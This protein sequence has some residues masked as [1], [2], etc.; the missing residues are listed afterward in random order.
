MRRT[1]LMFTFGIAL[2]IA[3]PGFLGAGDGAAEVITGTWHGRSH[4]E[5]LEVA[6]ACEEGEIDLVFRLVP[7]PE[8]EIVRLAAAK[9]VGDERV[10]MDEMDFVYDPA[11]W[12]WIS[13][14]RTEEF[15]GRWTYRIFEFILHG[16][17][18]VLPSHTVVQRVSAERP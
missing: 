18:V 9:R 13:E 8:G 3:A 6:P 17:L 5:D 2:G 7:G 15:H 1:A 12:S 16:T 11:T 10:P 14:V 4:C